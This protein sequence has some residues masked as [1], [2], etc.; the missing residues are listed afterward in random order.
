MPKRY[1]II[2]DADKIHQYVFSSRHLKLIRGA[3]AIQA[4]LNLALSAQILCDEFGHGGGAG[5][6]ELVYAGGGTLM[7]FFSNPEEAHAYCARI[8]GAFRKV[9]RVASVTSV[10]E[11]WDSE[12]EEFPDMLDRAMEHLEVNKTAKTEHVNMTSTPYWR[13]CGECGLYPASSPAKDAEGVDLPVCVACR[14]RRGEEARELIDYTGTSSPQEAGI[15]LSAHA[16]FESLAGTSSPQGYLALVYLDIDRLG[17]WLHQHGSQSPESYR[18]MSGKVRGAVTKGVNDACSKLC[19]GYEPG[20]LRPFEILLIGGDDAI[21]M[22]PAHL[23]FQFLDVFESKFNESCLEGLTFSA[24]V[25]WAHAQFPIAHFVAHAEDLL[26]SAKNR[27]GNAIDYMV[28]TESMARGVTERATRQT[29]RPYSVKD[30]V[31]LEKTLAEWKARGVP[32][33]K[34]KSLYR[35]AYQPEQQA[36]LDYLFLVSRLCLEHQK[37]FKDE[38]RY[39]LWE[40]D[41]RRTGVADLAELWDFTRIS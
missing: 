36:T 34:V 21:V 35:I 30:F 19:E 28:V 29:K 17:R 39:G 18:D 14:S 22:L 41:P 9:T 10:V 12:K 32:A 37:L 33:N 13:V 25:V 24:G 40:D 11:E 5:G 6:A 38:F 31:R 7:A 26:R 1:L 23:V 15:G 20:A 2:L 4:K 3:S 27:P 8:A 16:D